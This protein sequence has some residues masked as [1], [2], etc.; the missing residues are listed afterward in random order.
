MEEANNIYRSLQCSMCPGDTE[1]F[2]VLC[3]CDLCQQC[4]L[5]HVKDLNITG[6]HLIT[7][8]ETFAYFSTKGIHIHA[9]H[10]TNVPKQLYLYRDLPNF[11]EYIHHRN[12]VEPHIT[13]IQQHVEI[14]HTFR[15]EAR[16]F[17]PVLLKDIKADVKACQKE[18]SLYQSDILKKARRLKNLIDFGLGKVDF[19]ERYLNHLKEIHEKMSS[20]QKYEFIYELSAIRPVQFLLF[21]KE[22]RQKEMHLTLHQRKLSM[23]ESFNKDHVVKSL[24]EIEIKERGKRHVGNERLLKMKLV[25]EFIHSFTV[26]GVY[27]CT[28]ISC[29]ASNMVCIRDGTNIISTD[30]LGTAL[31]CL[32]NVCNRSE[33][34]H[35][36]NSESELIFIDENYSINKMS[37]DMK[38]ITTII[39]RT[40][41]T[42]DPWCVYWSPLTGD[43]LVGMYSNS[44][45]KVARY[46]KDGQETQLIQHDSTG[47]DLYREPCYIT[48]NYNGDVV[49]SNI[50]HGSLSGC[51][52]VTDHGGRHRFSYK[53][54]PSGSKIKPHGICTDVFKHIL[55]CDERSN[56]VH[57]LERDGQFLSHLLIRP[58]GI[59][60]PSGLGYDINTHRL[61]VGSL[62]SNRI[63]VYRYLSRQNVLHGKSGNH[64]LTKVFIIRF[65]NKQIKC[66][67]KICFH[68]FSMR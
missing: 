23:T 48:E 37:K 33:G 6:H 5:K 51:L 46:N 55:M 50:Y 35:T 27:G 49:V 45:G 65:N 67:I 22:I 24:I 57:I 30:T 31:H 28:H 12:Q 54:H 34:I 17:R 66:R 25:P 40:N 15:V 47:L 18:F 53:R 16:V 63:C 2:C 42:L 26:K 14:I 10:P 19:K 62:Y 8:S 29:L 38:T 7:Y 4:G 32:E 13:N 59:F 64:H 68:F 9:N 58:S 41:T 52:V 61:F 56:S 44:I 3:I 43:L 39:E 1:Y 20:I 60:K 11:N 36:V 21:K